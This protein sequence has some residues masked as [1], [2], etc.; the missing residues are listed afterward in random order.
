MGSVRDWTNSTPKW[1]KSMPNLLQ[2]IIND[3]SLEEG[4]VTANNST[5]HIAYRFIQRVFMIFLHARCKTTMMIG[6]Q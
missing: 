5:L 2:V 4:G 1:L 3:D 6:R